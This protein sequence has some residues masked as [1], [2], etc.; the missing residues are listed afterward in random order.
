MNNETFDAAAK[1]AESMTTDFY[2]RAGLA[3]GMLNEMT[4]LRVFIEADGS[5]TAHLMHYENR[6]ITQMKNIT[7]DDV[8][9]LAA[10]VK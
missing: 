6:T 4:S 5:T 7:A 8:R 1:V 9:R 2:R 10:T 3:R